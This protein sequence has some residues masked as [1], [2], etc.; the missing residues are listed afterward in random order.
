MV[1]V[2]ALYKKIA[3]T[4]SFGTSFLIYMT[5]KK[6]SNGLPR[7]FGQL[8]QLIFDIK[9]K[10]SPYWSFFIIYLCSDIFCT[11]I[12]KFCITLAFYKMI[13][14][15]S[16]HIKWFYNFFNTIL[17]SYIS[18]HKQALYLLAYFFLGEL[19]PWIWG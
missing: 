16:Y 12:S 6:G 2:H 11:K 5:P 18:I 17:L 14:D 1:A 19:L 4:T 15:S 10:I 7:D 9:I 3:K 8:L 13:N